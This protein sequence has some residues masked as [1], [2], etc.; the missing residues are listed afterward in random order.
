[1]E[2][3]GCAASKYEICFAMYVIVAV[4][5]MLKRVLTTEVF[6]GKHIAI[7]INLW[8]SI[9]RWDASSQTTIESCFLL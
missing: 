2:S 3:F 8:Y 6:I 9:T 1:M 4:L 5:K 7:W